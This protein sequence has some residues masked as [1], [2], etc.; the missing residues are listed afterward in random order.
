MKVRDEIEKVLKELYIT[1]D[2]KKIQMF[3]CYATVPDPYIVLYDKNDVEVR[4]CSHY[5]YIEVVGLNEKDYNY[6]FKKY[7]Y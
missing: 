6:L 2:C 1:L 7:G 4:Y 5:D 3:N